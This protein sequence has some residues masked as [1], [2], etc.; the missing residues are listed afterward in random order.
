MRS[1]QTNQAGIAQGGR[2]AAAVAGVAA[3]AALAYL[4]W[5]PRHGLPLPEALDAPRRTFDTQYAGRMAYYADV[6]G[7]GRPLVLVHSINAAPS[8]HEMRPLFEHYR[9][10]RP[11]Y[12][13]DLPGFGFSDRAR[14]RYTPELFGGAL[15]EFLSGV[16]NEPADVVALSLSSEFAARAALLAPR[17]V[18]SLTLI[19]PSGFDS[20]VGPS[21]S[22]QSPRVVGNIV[23]G[24][25]TLPVF[26]PLLYD[27]IVSR[28]GIRYY[29][30]KSFVGAPPAPFLGY[31]Y[32]TAHQPGARHAPLF[33]LSGLLFTRDARAVL[34]APLPMPALV[35]YDQDAYVDF[36]YLPE[37]VA[38]H[39]NWRAERI[40]PTRGLPHW[41]QLPATTA[42]LDR[43]WRAVE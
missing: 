25:L 18:A 6:R 38:R 17:L 36:D 37:F 33:F 14:R 23:H 31:N 10:T 12:A 16:V 32:A 9:G 8:A 11:V 39:P 41:E 43:F 26:G 2:A 24:L 35:L 40:A 29:L 22:M 15:F 7:T 20:P 4:R 5:G 30:G 13:V 42:A 28:P 21:P 34:Y 3:A 27:T 1:E 19:S